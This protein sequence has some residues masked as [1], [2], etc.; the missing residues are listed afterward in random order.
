MFMPNAFEADK[1]R[2]EVSFLV[3]GTGIIAIQ[4]ATLEINHVKTPG[5][6]DI[7]RDDRGL[8]TCTAG[9][10]AT[11]SDDNRH[12]VFS[13]H[14]AADEPA[15]QT[16]LEI[17]GSIR[18]KTAGKAETVSHTAQFDEMDEPV[19]LGPFEVAVTVQ[20]QTLRVK[21]T[22]PVELFAGLEAESG[23]EALSASTSNIQF[24]GATLSNI[25]IT[26]N[27]TGT[28]D[29]ETSTRVSFDNNAMRDAVK[30]S[31]TFSSNQ[32]GESRAYSF[33]LPKDAAEV[34]LSLTH[35]T[36]TKEQDLPFEAVV[37]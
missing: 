22:G 6:T 24:A 13:L 1:T 21:I 31:F 25:S 3:T 16:P 19:K 34:K 11:V 18:V 33:P 29:G 5:G 8:S 28:A 23:G 37:F 17:K 15:P 36:E 4:P 35:W 26:M 27:A 14:I 2:Y 10:N 30:N 20:R 32:D 12:G 7:A 9:Q